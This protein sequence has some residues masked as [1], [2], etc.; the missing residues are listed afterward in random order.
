MSSFDVWNAFIKASSILADRYSK[1]FE[2]KYERTNENGNLIFGY[3][4]EP[5]LSKAK[6]FLF[7]AFPDLNEEMVNF[8]D[9]YFSYPYN[10]DINLELVEDLK[11]FANENHIHFINK[12]CF[13]GKVSYT[14][15]QVE[16]FIKEHLKNDRDFTS[17]EEFKKEAKGYLRKKYPDYNISWLGKGNLLKIDELVLDEEDFFF[18]DIFFDIEYIITV[19]GVQKEE[20]FDSLKSNYVKKIEVYHEKRSVNFHIGANI[21]DEQL[22]EIKSNI[23]DYFNSQGI[24]NE[25]LS[26][27]AFFRRADKKKKLEKEKEYRNE[28]YLSL[29]EIQW[30]DEKLNKTEK[31]RRSSDIKAIID[32]EICKEFYETQINFIQEYLSN[33]DHQIEPSDYTLIFKNKFLSR[34][35][36]DVLEEQSIFA[37]SYH[38]LIFEIPFQSFKEFE[39]NRKDKHIYYESEE[40]NIHKGMILPDPVGNKLIFIF[41]DLENKDE[42]NFKAFRHLKSLSRIFDEDNI[43]ISHHHVICP[44]QWKAA[45]YIKS[46]LPDVY[47]LDITEE[48]I[49]FNFQTH[50]QLQERLNYLKS[51]ENINVIDQTYRVRLESNTPLSTIAEKLNEIPSVKAD[52]DSEEQSINFTCFFDDLGSAPHLETR[53][54]NII[55]EYDDPYVKGHINSQSSGKVKYKFAFDKDGFRQEVKK[56]MNNLVG[57]FIR[58]QESN[59]ILGEVLEVTS[60]IMKIDPNSGVNNW[61]FKAPIKVYGQLKGEKDKL[62]RLQTTVDR[63]F[64]HPSEMVNPNLKDALINFEVKSDSKGDNTNSKEYLD[65]KANV[66]NN[67]LSRNLNEK[68]IEAVAKCLIKENMFLIQGPPGTGK[69][70][71]IAELVWQHVNEHLKNNSSK[72]YKILVTSET[73]LAVDNAL[74]KLASDEHTLIKPIRFGSEDKLD[75]EGQQFSLEALKKWKENGEAFEYSESY[76]LDQWIKQIKKRASSQNNEGNEYLNKWTHYLE[77]KNNELRK[78]FFE[79]YINNCN[80]VG[81]T[82]SSIGKLNSVNKFTRFFWDYCNVYHTSTYRSNFPAL[83]KKNIEF[84]LVIQDEASKATPPE[85]SLPF[86]YAKKGVIIGDHRQLPP[87]VHVDDFIDEM[88]FLK[89]ISEVEEEK[90]QIDQL[91]QFIKLNKSEFQTSHFEKLYTHLPEDNKSRFDLQYRMHPAI[92]E[93]IKQFYIDDGGLNCGLVEPVDKGVDDPD[94]TNKASRYHGITKSPDTHVMWFDVKSPEVRNGT[95]RVNY[96]EVKAVKW[97]IDKL[98]NTEGFEKYYNHWEDGQIEEKEIGV[99]TFYG[100]QA[101]ELNKLN[102]DFPLKISPVDRFQG[103]ERGIVIVSLVRSDRIAKNEYDKPSYEDYSD[104]YPR[105][106]SLGFAQYPNRLNVALSRAKRLLIIIGNSDHFRKKAIYDKVYETIKSHP[107]GK[108]FDFERIIEK[109]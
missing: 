92:N 53:V 77:E 72:N 101:A 6:Q 106:E 5:P 43:N 24:D 85:L 39:K 94:L 83:K 54:S 23:K 59:E 35:L 2:I 78:N 28:Q 89:K 38:E 63:L 69:S 42:L 29:E 74:G 57:E 14:N 49:T 73:N 16:E 61:E 100:A 84:D 25:S 3:S 68:Q 93:T 88:A 30:I 11:S 102:Y 21:T 27:N 51:K 79:H 17:F 62:I 33:I 105:Q 98:S 55:K 50:S 109:Y 22:Y 66:K 34:E 103:M 1:P 36:L 75:Q 58:D 56:Q 99:I 107:G 4:S 86:I 40:K 7:E 18:L 71:A 12:P 44:A 52:L 97:I 64:K 47:E 82:C 9:G 80:V 8:E 70:T 108:V 65:T 67:L 13:T 31:V 90:V 76:I 26:L 91:I 95:S 37:N 96:G 104:D 48:K 60:S 46:S 45:K 32:F 10:S 15:N 87:M 19:K 20:S 41:T 81:A